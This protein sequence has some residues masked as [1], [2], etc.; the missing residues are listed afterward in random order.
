MIQHMEAVRYSKYTIDI[1]DDLK[2]IEY[3]D[4]FTELTGYSREDISSGLTQKQLIFEE[5]WDEYWD[6]VSNT[7]KSFKEA[8]FD[9]RLK[10]KSGR[11]ISVICFG[12]MDGKIIRIFI[13]DI[14][15]TKLLKS[16]ITQMKDQLEIQNSQLRMILE[17]TEEKII[18][19]HIGSDNCIIYAVVNDE[20]VKIED[21][22]GASV[23]DSW[24][25]KIYPS[26]MNVFLN[27]FNFVKETGKDTAFECRLKIGS[28]ND[29][30]W[31]NVN[32]YS[33]ADERTGKVKEIIGRIRS[34]HKEKLVTLE[35]RNRS[36]RDYLTGLYNQMYFKKYI[37]RCLETEDD[38]QCAFIM[39]DLDN[40]KNINDIYGHYMG[41]KVIISVAELLIGVC[42]SI[43]KVCRMG[44]DEFAV[45]F[46]RCSAEEVYNVADRICCEI[47]GIST[48][49]EIDFEITGSVGLTFR[50][51]ENDDFFALYKRADK[52]MYEAKNSGKGKWMEI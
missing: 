51:Y 4:H 39:M 49:N 15:D 41:D 33:I 44:G 16:E 13:A 48:A 10:T 9:H 21:I 25:S 31:G 27:N 34:I 30:V 1:D 40:F 5:E 11:S 3:D 22:K 17:G 23:A 12:S 24:H 14:T 35:L 38:S 19:Y 37:D 32:L 36:E 50:R 26:D 18:N 8:C 45:F 52:A 47:S 7:L 29:Y 6:S 42:G 43:A 46:N 28:R 2:I 20:Y